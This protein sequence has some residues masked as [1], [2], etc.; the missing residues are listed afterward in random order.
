MPSWLT[1]TGWADPDVIRY[2]AWVSVWGRWLI[3]L[4][5]V[6]QFAYRPGFWYHE[7]HFEYLF[8][9][10]PFVTLNALVHYR[11]L[12]NRS[13]TWRW[14]FFLSAMDMA[15]FTI[16][17]VLQRG[18][19]G[20]LFLAYYPALV[21]FVM[22]FPSLVLGLAWTTMN[23]VVYALVSLRVGLGLDLVAGD[24]KDLLARVAAMYVLVL[25]VSFIVR[26]E[27]IRRQAA[28]ERER[29]L[30]RE[31]IELSQAIHD[32][33]AQTAYMI[34]LGIHR[35][36]ELAGE[37]NEELNAALDATST[38]SK[39]AMW[40]LRRPIDEGRLFEGRELQQVLW[41]HCATFERITSVPAKV[42]QSGTEP[43]LAMET[44]SRLFSIAHNALTNAFLHARPGRVDVR[45]GF[46]S[47]SIRLS[48][49]D[50]GVG[51]PDDYAERGRGFNGMRADA[52]RMG[53]MLV[54]ESSGGGTTITCVVPRAADRGG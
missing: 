27:R 8:L 13:V 16:G 26:F 45:L 34:G 1:P 31:R 30:Q 44:R 29:H 39:S 52:E 24:E 5:I 9:P 46:E 11:L 10:V 49:S 28:V 47:D 6:V 19:E 43:P 18:F 22:A 7:G 35:A 4:V 42:S 14:M 41:S 36:R 53:G 17:I 40:E 33:T 21:L 2:T 54:V 48:V 25:C 20:F 51:L 12:T 38:L 15:T 32:T 50:D 3:W 37:S 23:A